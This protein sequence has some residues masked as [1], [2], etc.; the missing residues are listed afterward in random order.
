MAY[1]INTLLYIINPLNLQ[2][3]MS[4]LLPSGQPHQIEM[5]LKKLNLQQNEQKY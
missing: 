4:T 1:N 5:A 2:L 3:I